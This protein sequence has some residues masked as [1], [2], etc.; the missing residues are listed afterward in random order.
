MGPTC[1][2]P[3]CEM[4]DAATLN[5]SKPQVPT[6]AADAPTLAPSRVFALLSDRG[7]VRHSN[8]DAC[9]ALPQHGV[10]VVCDGMGGAAGGEVASHLA[11]QTF[12]DCLAHALQPAATGSATRPRARLAEAIRAANQ[13]VY[14]H[15]RKLPSL[16]GMGTT[17]VALLWDDEAQ[18]PEDVPTSPRLWIAHVGDSRCYLFR[19]G[20]LHQ[21]TEDHS[22]V[23]E[24]VRA[25]VLSRVQATASPMRNI[26]TRAIG[27][28]STVEP[29]IASHAAQP[30]DLYLLASDGL[31][32]ELDDEE[33]AQILGCTAGP[34]E[35]AAACRDSDRRNYATAGTALQAALDTACHALVEASNAKGGRDNIT[36]LLVACP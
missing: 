15:S 21:L 35:L 1:G 28:Q 26:I 27:S 31:T 8:Q 3:G 7:R 4:A 6:A 32:R 14:R 17:L 2:E 13:A 23:E 16:H 10:F 24:Q 22:L 12:L 11:T 33:I 20:E 9:A 25:G 5:C 34:A 18:R 29:E 30:G 19:S 36:V